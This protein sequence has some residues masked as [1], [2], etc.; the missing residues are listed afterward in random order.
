MTRNKKTQEKNP[1][2]KGKHKVKCSESI[3]LKLVGRL[4]DKSRIAYI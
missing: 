2:V 1:I 3:T 4:K